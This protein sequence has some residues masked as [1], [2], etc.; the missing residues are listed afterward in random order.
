MKNYC[1][2]GSNKLLLETVAEPK[3]GADLPEGAGE[4]VHRDE[5]Q[6]GELDDPNPRRS[7]VQQYRQQAARLPLES[8]TKDELANWTRHLH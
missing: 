3:E 7:N 2:L 4:D 8:R 6:G 1:V 5:E